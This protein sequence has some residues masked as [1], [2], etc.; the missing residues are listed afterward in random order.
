M[1]DEIKNKLAYDD[2]FP[3]KGIRFIDICPILYDS[4]S[5]KLAIKLLSECVQKNYPNVTHL[6]ALEARGFM[7]APCV[8]FEL[9]IPFVPVRKVGKLP[10]E[11][12][13]VEY[14][15]EYGKV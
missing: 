9:N 14:T 3:I 5:F 7:F 15:K 1:A 8:A 6:L 12:W 13:T 11:C 2:D 4:Q 10:G